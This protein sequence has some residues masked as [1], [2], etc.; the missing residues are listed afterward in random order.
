ML[1]FRGSPKSSRRSI[2]L[3]DEMRREELEAVDNSTKQSLFRRLP[4]VIVL[5]FFSSF[6][7][8]NSLAVCMYVCIR[9]HLSHVF[10]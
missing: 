3:I 8:I 1:V 4:K 2:R 6:L 5:L 9:F 7:L 10:I